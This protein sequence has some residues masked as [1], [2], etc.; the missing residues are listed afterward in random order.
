MMEFTM[1]EI[2]PEE[3]AELEK[4][5][6]ACFTFFERL[7][8]GRPQQG[9]VIEEN[10][11]LCGGAF[12]KVV[13]F[14]E[15]KR[16][17]Y[18]DVGFVCPAYRGTGV[19]DMLY[20]GAVEW[21]HAQ[22]CKYVAAMIIDENLRSKAR[23]EAAGLHESMFMDM[24]R[25]VGWGGVAKFCFRFFAAALMGTNCK[26][27]TDMPGSNWGEGPSLAVMAVFNMLALGV[28][29]FL[30]KGIDGFEVAMQAGGVMLVMST[31]GSYLG[32]RIAGGK[33]K[34]AVP[35]GGAG[36]S[37]AL[38]AMGSFYPWMGRMYPVKYEKT[39][40]CAKRLGICGLTEWLFVLVTTL[41]CLY[42]MA[43]H[44]ALERA[45]MYGT[46]FLFYH[47]IPC[48]PFSTMGQKRVWEWNKPV[49]I[50]LMAVSFGIFAFTWWL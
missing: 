43:L 26:L 11:N 5:A 10:G 27:Y 40:Q 50:A 20:K 37:F 3:A 49:C 12:L 9:V 44:P 23:A 1:R 16:I 33:W 30:T 46:V 22:G 14:A 19:A 36:L 41:L 4:K 32:A 25:Y 29:G 34:Y 17:G 45:A 24:S 6:R 31:L 28:S 35:S 21:L 42:G 15:D 38:M 18:I 48:F 2:R 13:D 7:G 47:S 8:V 39:P